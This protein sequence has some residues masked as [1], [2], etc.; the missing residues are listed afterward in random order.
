[1]AGMQ[2]G[3]AYAS[4]LLEQLVQKLGTRLRPALDVPPFTH[5]R[6]RDIALQYSQPVYCV[7]VELGRAAAQ[8]TRVSKRVRRQSRLSDGAS[9]RFHFARRV[10]IKHLSLSASKSSPCYILC[11]TDAHPAR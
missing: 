11:R 7:G 9:H 10:F 5:S 1:M 3:D 6:D 4:S 8:N 2:S